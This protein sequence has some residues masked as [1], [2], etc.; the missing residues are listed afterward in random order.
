VHYV[1][2]MVWVWKP[3]RAKK[4]ARIF[5]HL[6]C[7]LAFE[8]PYFTPYGLAATHVGHPVIE[9]GAGKGDGTAFRA[10]HGIDPAATVLCLLPGSR[11]NEVTRMLPVL[12]DAADI[13][14]TR[15]PDLAVVIPTV[16]T[17]ADLVTTETASWKRPPHIV[18]G[19]AERWDAF[20]A[21]DAAMA[22]SGTVALELAQAR[23]PFVIGYRG[24]PISAWLA[25][26]MISI[27]YA[28][29]L[30]HISNEMIVP[31]YLQDAC[32]PEILAAATDRLLCDAEART[33]FL[34]RTGAALA[35]LVGPF[36]SPSDQAADV[37]LRSAGIPVAP[38]V[39]APHIDRD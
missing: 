18:R 39:P 38:P 37:V 9:G 7:L 4:I 33:T 2:P 32:T 11:A 25:R 15:H 30:N 36:A 3:G 19:E 8:P 31:E 34:A 13:L 20:A 1:A 21:A 27:K 6:M 23:V 12:R 16:A 35:E 22:T 5:D 17:V 29:L 24:S 14:R 28:T 10:R 26:K